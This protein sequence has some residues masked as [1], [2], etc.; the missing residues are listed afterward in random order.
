LELSLTTFIL[1]IINFLVLVW[2]LKRLLFVPIKKSIE[3]RKMEIKKSLEDAE[4]KQSLA[5]KLFNQYE[6][7]LKDWEKEKKA[8][9]DE[10]KKELD[11]EREHGLK[12]IGIE[13]SKKQDRLQAQVDK[14]QKETKDKMER[15]AINQS[16]IFLSKLLTNFSS[17]ELESSII[18][19][20]LENLEIKSDVRESIPPSGTDRSEQSILVRSAFPL[21]ENERSLLNDKI[22]PLFKTN[23][24]VEFSTDP[25]LLAGLE[26]TAGFTV[27]RA[28]I[29]DELRYFSM[30][31]N[32][33]N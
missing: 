30:V 23:A 15:E 9:F 25:T 31:E 29:R 21:A 20:F 27:I 4:S 17:K 28:N 24:N 19:I 33:G 13:I 5:T 3:T 8:K 22:A 10:L 16:L 6:N 12:Q 14:A 11:T 1:E 2:I 18:R 26:I 7:R 32:N